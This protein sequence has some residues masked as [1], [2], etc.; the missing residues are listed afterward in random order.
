MYRTFVLF[1]IFYTISILASDKI[2]EQARL[3]EYDKLYQLIESLY[4]SSSEVN[5]GSDLLLTY[6]DAKAILELWEERHS[7]PTK[8][9]QHIIDEISSI[10][11]NVNNYSQIKIKTG[12]DYFYHNSPDCTDINPF[13]NRF[14]DHDFQTKYDDR[15]RFF[16]ATLEIPLYKSFFLST[17]TA[18]RNHW[19]YFNSRQSDFPRDLKEFNS[20]MNEKS[21]LSCRLDNILINMGRDRLSLGLGEFNKLLISSNLPPTDHF[22]FSMNHKDNLALTFI[23]A[24]MRNAEKEEE[25]PKI[26][27]AHRLSYRFFNRFTLAISEMQMT[28]QD[29]NYKYINPFL[30]YHNE[31]EYPSQRNILTA[32]DAEVILGYG[33]KTYASFAVDE[34]DVSALEENGNKGREAWG[35][36]LGLKQIQPFGIFNTQW[37]MEWTKLT[38][39]MYNHGFPYEDYYTLNFVY[40]EKRGKTDTYEFHRFVGHELGSNVEALK[41]KF[42]WQELNLLFKYI[43]QGKIPI[44]S[45]AYSEYPDPTK[46]FSYV[47]GIQYKKTFWKNRIELKTA[48]HH[49]IKKNFHQYSGLN[50][51]Y[52][53]FWLSLNYQLFNL[54]WK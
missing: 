28:N 5:P 44:L 53:E 49:T 41:T 29:L 30:A 24:W 23:I 50:K 8:S 26:L 51:S 52:S 14:R 40:E 17:R 6:K 7:N 25:R 16:D 42:K 48:L 22:Q 32:A 12:I 10:L 46:E 36:I 3:Y 2:H 38:K 9:Q 33:I 37:V 45:R 19:K 13:Y 11:Q 47:F 27:Y 31:Y 35:L 18:L 20:N 4:L 15:G 1:T 43:E 39:W 34:I 54:K 21:I